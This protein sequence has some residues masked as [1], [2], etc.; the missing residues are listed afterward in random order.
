MRIKRDYMGNDQLLPAYNVQVGIADEYIV[1]LDVNQSRSDMDCF[2][3]LLEKFYEHH[4]IYPKYPVAD[5][6]YGSFN[7]YLYCSKHGM[8]ACMK[9]PMFFKETTVEKTHSVQSI[10]RRRWMERCSVPTERSSNSSTGKTFEA[11][12]MA[13]RK[14]SMNVRT[15]VAVLMQNVARKHLITD[16]SA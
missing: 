6:G 7:N 3:P 8:E 14:K 1:V 13:V 5:A 11:T 2:V 15:A 16:G 9:F 4:G 10:S 12:N